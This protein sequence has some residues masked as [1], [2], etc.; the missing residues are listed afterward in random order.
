MDTSPQ[1]ASREDIPA[2]TM[3]AHKFIFGYLLILILVAAV[4]G[5]YAWQHQRVVSL[6][7]QVSSLQRKE[8]VTS[9]PAPKP[10][11]IKF[12]RT[13]G[14]PYDLKT[15]T[16]TTN[17][18]VPTD[19]EAV[20]VRSNL[21]NPGSEEIFSD[22]ENDEMARY[23]LGYTQFTSDGSNDISIF[24]ISPSWLNSSNQRET[25]LGYDGDAGIEPQV[26]LQTPAS[27]TQ[28]IQGL[29]SI[30]KECIKDP[31]KGF[32]TKDKVFSICYKVDPDKYGGPSALVLSGYAEAQ[33]EPLILTGI[34]LLDDHYDT[35]NPSTSGVHLQ[36]TTDATKELIDALSQ[37]TVTAGARSL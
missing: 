7:S 28:Y 17:L 32:Q 29:A 34:M 13:V 11:Q 2:H 37:S 1:N 31:T 25:Y 6:S 5:T 18:G 21:K 19:V 27:K 14:F 23:T 22:K 9:T 33:G 4:A 8:H 26:I 3:H 12:V 24:A 20:Q 36:S 15:I 30:T 10:A 35:L 16:I